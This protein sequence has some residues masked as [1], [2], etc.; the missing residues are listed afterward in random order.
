MAASPCAGHYEVLSTNAALT[1]RS[2][3]H[4]HKHILNQIVNSWRKD[5]LLSLREVRSSKLSGSGSVVQVGDVVILKDKHVKRAFWKF[6]KVVEP[7]RG[8]DGI[9]RAALINVST[10]S[11]PPRY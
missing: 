3:S 10:G 5:Y 11:G 6:A 7:L 1:R 8:S 4:K 9:A 2:R